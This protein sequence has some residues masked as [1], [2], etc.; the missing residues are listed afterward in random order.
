MMTERERER[1][2]MRI[3]MWIKW[4]NWMPLTFSPKKQSFCSNR[5]SVI[6]SSLSF[7]LLG[8]FEEHDATQRAVRRPFLVGLRNTTRTISFVRGGSE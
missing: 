7:F 6:R 4:K 5:G 2:Y 3:K 8:R 1:V